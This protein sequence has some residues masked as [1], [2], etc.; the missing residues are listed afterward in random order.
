MDFTKKQQAIFYIEGN[1]AF[2]YPS[3]TSGETLQFPFPTDIVCD[4]EVLE[5]QKFLALILVFFQSH[6]IPPSDILVV[7]AATTVFEKDF[8]K[9]QNQEDIQRFIDYI[10]FDEVLTKTFKADKTIK[11]IAINKEFY[12]ILKEACEIA[13]C[14]IVDV[15]AYTSLLPIVPELAQKVDLPLILTKFDASRQFSIT[16]PAQNISQ[17]QQPL[18]S[19]KNKRTFIL[20]GVFGVLVVIL[21]IV[22]IISNRPSLS[23][24]QKKI[25][26]PVPVVTLAV[27]PTIS[28]IS[29]SAVPTSS[30]Q[31]NGIATSSALDVQMGL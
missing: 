21:F 7:F 23:Q 15:V 2:F 14:H 11:V 9:E 4:L 16:T 31:V 24:S 19:A 18:S 22:I 30:E 27:S 26:K 17:F 5:R 6:K 13:K 29:P 10:P 3:S 8:P 12:D 20:L 25:I 1:R 28:E